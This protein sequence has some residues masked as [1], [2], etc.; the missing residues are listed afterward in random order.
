MSRIFLSIVCLVA[1]GACDRWPGKPNPDSRWKPASEVT[2]FST[3]YRQ[4]CLGCHGSGEIVGASIAMD[5]ATYLSVVPRDVLV[6]V[7]SKGVPGTAMPGFSASVGGTLTDKQIEILVNGILAKKPAAPPAQLPAYAGSLGDPSRGAG[8][9]AAS[10][11]SCHGEK[12]TGGEKAG[13]V[14]NPAYLDLVSDQYLRTIAIAGRSDLGC[15]D[16]ANRTPGKPLTNTDIADVTAWLVSQRKNEFGK[17][18]T[19]AVPSNP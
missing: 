3:L 1:L 19:P 15:P 8:V 7:I 6:N 10:C 13:S 12:G 16:F 5:N 11:A 4:N 2:D 14:V 9:F 18:L 17:P